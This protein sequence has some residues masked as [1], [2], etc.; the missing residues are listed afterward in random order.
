MIA[1]DRTGDGDRRRGPV[2]G[3]S[4]ASKE[5]EIKGRSILAV[6]RRAA[7][8]IVPTPAARRSSGGGDRPVVGGGLDR[9]T[10]GVRH[11]G[12]GDLHVSAW[13]R[14]RLAGPS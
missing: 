5:P 9:R 13:R 6:A 12:G 7:A 10:T 1:S 8:E 14:S 3:G 4:S 11:Q 2:D